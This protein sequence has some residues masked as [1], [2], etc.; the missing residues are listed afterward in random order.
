[1]SYQNTVLNAGNYYEI[2]KYSI[3]GKKQCVQTNYFK[4]NILLGA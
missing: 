4:T 3:N 2:K 1:M